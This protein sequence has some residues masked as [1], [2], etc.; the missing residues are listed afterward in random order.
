VVCWI[1]KPA[2][3]LF[4]FI[5]VLISEIIKSQTALSQG[6]MMDEITQGSLVWPKIQRKHP[7]NVPVHCHAEEAMKPGHTFLKLTPNMMNV[8]N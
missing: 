6:S 5:T 4:P 2:S 1:N 3:N 8:D 7:Q